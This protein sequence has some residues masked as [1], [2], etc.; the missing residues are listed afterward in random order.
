MSSRFRGSNAPAVQQHRIAASAP[1]QPCHLAL[2]GL[3][4]LAA[5]LLSTSLG[6][7]EQSSAEEVG[8]R[9]GQ[10]APAFTLK[11]QTGKEVSLDALLKKGPVALVF[12]RSA[13]WCLAC[14]L[15]LVKLQGNLKEIES[16]GGQLVGI[17][18][19]STKTLKCFADKKT[20]TI[21]I[22]SD[23]D[24]KTIDAYGVR[25]TRAEFEKSGV[26]RHIIIVV[27]QKGI[28]RSKR[29]GVIY[30]ERPGVNYLARALKEAQNSNG[31]TMR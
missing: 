28:V 6:A 21:P 17:S 10:R 18:Y 1:A 11:D 30:D 19:D 14:G 2:T 24:S 26:A 3:C 27:D 25:D 8:L 13:D 5:A 31:G 7:A 12:F 9:I 20:I 15:Q 23:V 4:L 22:L 16:S 29:L